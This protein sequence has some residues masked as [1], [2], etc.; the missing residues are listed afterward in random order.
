M[1]PSI[2]P[3][4]RFAVTAA[5]VGAAVFGSVALAPVA[6][7][8]ESTPVVEQAPV[9]EEAPAPAPQAPPAPPIVYDKNGKPIKAPQACTATQ[10]DQ[11]ERSMAQATRLAD[12]LYAAA[13]KLDE[14]AGTLRARAAQVSASAGTVLTALAG[15]SEKASDKLEERAALL[16]EEAGVLPCV[17]E[18][19][20]RF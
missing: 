7:A 10:M 6:S 4:R 13:A 20:G 12:A 16:L 14:A 9:V 2:S 8:D 3:I 19:G 5:M 17:P 1:S 15:G 18:G 11:Y